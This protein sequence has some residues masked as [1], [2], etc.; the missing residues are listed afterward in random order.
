MICSHNMCFTILRR[1]PVFWDTF[2]FVGLYML[3]Q[4]ILNVAP[5]NH[6]AF[7][8]PVPLNM[9]S[10]KTELEIR[11]ILVENATMFSHLLPGFFCGSKHL[12]LP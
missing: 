4:Q 9:P 5:A 3:L 11:G 10:E 2:F 8:R 12:L 7:C 6:P 1:L